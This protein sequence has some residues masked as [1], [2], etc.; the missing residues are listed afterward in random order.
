MKKRKMNTIPYEQ[1]LSTRSQATNRHALIQAIE[2]TEN[3]NTALASITKE[4]IY[5]SELEDFVH[6]NK[7]SNERLI[8]F[9]H[10][11]DNLKTALTKFKQEVYTQDTCDCESELAKL[12]NIVADNIN[13]QTGIQMFYEHACKYADVCL[14]S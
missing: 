10:S 13:M 4:L 9:Q 3:Y 11:L 8:E 12:Q 5:V 6:V 1:S 2:Q 7:E 14:Q